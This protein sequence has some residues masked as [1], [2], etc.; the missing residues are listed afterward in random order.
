MSTPKTGGVLT[1][2]TYN[3]KTLTGEYEITDLSYAALE[4]VIPKLKLS[5]AKESGAYKLDGVRATYEIIAPSGI[6]SHRLI[7]GNESV[8]NPEDTGF[9]IPGSKKLIPL[10]RSDVV[11]LEITYGQET[12]QVLESVPAVVIINKN[13]NPES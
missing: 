13:V 1:L 7:Y 6:T 2:Q 11:A 4:G 3:G 8:S 12:F 10:E 9:I 5:R